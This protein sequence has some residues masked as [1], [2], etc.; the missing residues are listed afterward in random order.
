MIKKPGNS[1]FAE[2]GVLICSHRSKKEARD[3]HATVSDLVRAQIRMPHKHPNRRVKKHKQREQTH[4]PQKELVFRRQH[5]LNRNRK[6]NPMGIYGKL[7]SKSDYITILVDAAAPWEA[8]RKKL[9]EN[10]DFQAL[11]RAET[12]AIKMLEGTRVIG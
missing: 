6:S 12:A 4:D 1:W 5:P 2:H 11:L 7:Y 10:P 3:P 9:D 8:K